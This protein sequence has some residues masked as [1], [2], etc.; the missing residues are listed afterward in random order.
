MKP[1]FAHLVKRRQVEPT[2][3]WHSLSVG[4]SAGLILAGLLSLAPRLPAA[5]DPANWMTRDS[6]TTESLNCIAH[7][8]DIFV[9]V[10]AQGVLR[11][12]SDGGV[13]W[14]ARDSGTNALLN[15]VV[16]ADGLFV[17]AGGAFVTNASGGEPFVEDK[18]VI[19]TSPD[20][21]IWTI[22]N[23]GAGVYLNAIAYGGGR[24]VAVGRRGTILVSADGTNWLDRSITTNTTF[25]SVTHTNG[26]YFVGG[27]SGTLLTSTDA[28]DWVWHDQHVFANFLAIARL[29]ETYI[30]AG[31]R[32]VV[33]TSP[34]GTN[35]IARNSGISTAI[36]DLTLGDCS[37]LAAGDAGTI[38]S[39]T[40]GILWKDW[41]GPIS[42]RLR[43]SW[44]EDHRLT[45]VGAA[46]TIA[47][48][49][50]RVPAILQQPLDLTVLDGS[51]ARL[52]VA[53]LADC[54]TYQWL[55]DG[56]A[57]PGAD[58]SAL[59]WS[60]V[61]LTAAGTYTVVLSNAFGA[62][63]S[64]P[65][66][67]TVLE[68]PP[69]ITVQPESQYRIHR[70]YRHFQRWR[71]WI[72]ATRLPVEIQR[73][74][75]GRNDERGVDPD[76]RAGERRRQLP[77]NHLEP[78]RQCFQWLGEPG[79]YR[80]DTLDSCSIGSTVPRRRGSHSIVGLRGGSAAVVPSVVQK[81]R[82]HCRRHQ[83]RAG[84]YE[85]ATGRLGRLHHAGDQSGGKRSTA[86]LSGWTSESVRRS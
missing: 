86:Q 81:Q 10:G 31:S 40:D 24:F 11:T 71:H 45:V 54:T 50:L 61:T 30:A 62:I 8:N 55:Q 64:A 16:W 77:G 9:A 14:T 12:S 68:T 60:N 56:T 23:P 66:V 76:E 29:N 5:D 15:A 17:A 52:S 41:P 74:D 22:Q 63:T 53:A 84:I 35:W 7:G 73:R 20:G 70:R 78:P 69:I 2:T 27:S 83:Q 51:A 1:R 80:I 49:D 59:S 46:G 38:A 4:G 57:L 82:G 47:Q 18:P 85:S 6:G 79:C 48:L 72:A 13:T 44:F 32:G 25:Y 34:D 28:A 19:L 26:L 42:Q 43:A 3:P 67:L 37:V 36:F 39:S 33:Y 21:S 75:V 65:A 58:K